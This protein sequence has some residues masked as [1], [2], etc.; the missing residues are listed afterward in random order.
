MTNAITIFLGLIAGMIALYQVK[1]NIISNSRIKWIETL[2]ETISE[3]CM[4]IS[5]CNILKINLL[6]E[7]KRLKKNLERKESDNEILLDRYY[8]P[9][10]E[11]AKK[12]EKLHVKIMLYLNSE[13]DYHRKME[14]LMIKNT[15]LIRKFEIDNS[16]E[17]DVNINEMILGSKEIFRIEWKKSKRV[18]KR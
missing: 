9:Y 12:A 14:S 5:N 18:F 6:D 13:N 17:L 2:R 3:Y 7:N 15:T 1:L 16:N 8:I 4:E 11:S 10:S